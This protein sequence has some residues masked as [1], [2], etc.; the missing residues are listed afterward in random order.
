MDITLHMLGEIKLE[1]EQPEVLIR[2]DVAQIGSLDRVDV[3][4]VAN[5]GE[6]AALKK[7]AA[8]KKI[9]RRSRRK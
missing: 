8:L 4:H 6:Q 1:M 5:L 3:H 7:K 2:P 9:K